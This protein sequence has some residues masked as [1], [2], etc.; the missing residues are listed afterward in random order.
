MFHRAA[1]VKAGSPWC[2]VLTVHTGRYGSAKAQAKVVAAV[3]GSRK[4]LASRQFGPQ[5]TVEQS[6]RSMTRPKPESQRPGDYFRREACAAPF[7]GGGSA[8][9]QRRGRPVPNRRP[10][11][12]TWTDLSVFTRNSD[13]TE[14]DSAMLRSDR[15]CASEST[16]S[17][18]LLRGR[19][20]DRTPDAT[21]T[22]QYQSSGTIRQPR[23]HPQPGHVFFFFSANHSVVMPDKPR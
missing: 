11:Y 21:D 3:A 1:T 9:R 20:R 22:A 10:R 5:T 14:K 16:L 18:L 19:S 4:Q 13:A 23:P 17:G 8:S 2:N 15:P 7:D 12:C 6:R